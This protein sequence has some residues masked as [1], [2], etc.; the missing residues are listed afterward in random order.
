[1]SALRC[2]DA[3]VIGA[4]VAGLAAAR[5]LVDAGLSTLV[6]EARDR[7]GGRILT[8]DKAGRRV[9]LGAEFVHGNPAE[10]LKLI[11]AAHLS[12]EEIP[13]T[14][15]HARNGKLDP[16][17]NFW[18]TIG[19]LCKQLEPPIRG[20]RKDL[21][22]VL[23]LSRTNIGQAQQV[24]LLNFV[25]G[26][27]AGDPRKI[28]TRWLVDGADELKS[29]YK[30][31]RLANGYSDMVTWLATG[32]DPDRVEIRLNT[33]ATE[34]EWK[35]HEA[36][37]WVTSPAG[38][39]LGPFSA[40]AVI[41]TVPHAVL[42]QGRLRMRPMDSRKQNAL[43]QL[44][45]GHIFKLVLQFRE[46][47]WSKDEFLSKRVKRKK[48]SASDPEAPVFIHSQDE[49]VPVWW[50]QAPSTTPNLTAW[51]GGPKAEALLTETHQS[52]LDKSLNALSRVFDMSRRNIDEMLESCSTHDWTADPFSMGAYTY[53]GAGALRAAKVL[54]EPVAQT[55]F[56]AGEAT[57]AAEMG[58]VA[59]AL[60]TGR[61]AAAQCARTLSRRR[62]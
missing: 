43:Q 48:S 24:L 4:G 7:V 30:Q 27:E 33:T 35:R 15:H 11:Q 38:S 21:P 25:E 61:R 23:S 14:H 19:G 36:K 26:F 2:H 13:D 62:P 46:N 16:F 40:R 49:D 50:T 8:V 56:F 37:V 44:E 3:I 34:L 9:E 55:L 18:P 10:V 1:V 59:A 28:S 57:D 29:S 17:H 52:R 53:V 47:F 39:R 54:A 12:L 58:T 60:S 20:N 41:V 22:L 6:L 51:A 32:L 45:V 31:F 42:K 5:V